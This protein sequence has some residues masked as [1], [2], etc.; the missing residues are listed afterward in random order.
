MRGGSTSIP[1]RGGRLSTLS[2]PL[3]ARLHGSKRY[4][5]LLLDPHRAELL[6]QLAQD[7]GMRTT[8]YARELL[9]S[10][11]KRSTETATYGLAEAQDQ[12]LRRKSIQNQVQGRLQ[13]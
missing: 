6:E 7:A 11:I 2:H 10:A 8:A 9:Y 1:L 13:A 12:A 3:M 5:Q 4:Y